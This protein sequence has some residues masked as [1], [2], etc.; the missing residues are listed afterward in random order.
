MRRLR[1][2]AAAGG[3]IHRIQDRESVAW[4]GG[5]G[6]NHLVLA[7][8]LA[9]AV[10]LAECCAVMCGYR[11][12]EASTSWGLRGGDPGVA[13]A[14][15]QG[16]F[17]Q[18][19][20][21][22]LPL[23]SAPQVDCLD[24]AVATGVTHLPDQD[25]RAVAGLIVHSH[26]ARSRWDMGWPIEAPCRLV[27]CHQ[28]NPPPADS[29]HT[30]GYVSHGPASFPAARRGRGEPPAA[31]RARSRQGRLFTQRS[32]R[33]RAQL[34][35]EVLAIRVTRRAC[36]SPGWRSGPGGR[37]LMCAPA[38]RA[39]ERSAMVVPDGS[40]RAKQEWA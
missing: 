13:G 9:A 38:G 35:R 14:F 24:P 22:S 6:R 37:L 7:Q 1:V 19:A 12:E 40:G 23:P 18:Q 26:H 5:G 25:R 36:G 16:P 3:G 33:A 20:A 17:D 11:G 4:E 15:A 27:R 21:V 2:F 39:G 34:G 10:V 29:A 28:P 32:N 8:V 30:L 31:W